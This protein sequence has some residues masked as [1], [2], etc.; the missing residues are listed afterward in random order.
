VLTH[1]GDGMLANA[2]KVDLSRC[3][4]A[5]DGMVVDF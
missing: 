2:A 5:D 4:L 1:M 3:K